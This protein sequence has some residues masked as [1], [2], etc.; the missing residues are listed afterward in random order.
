V[1]KLL[2]GFIM[3]LV[4]LIIAYPLDG[5]KLQCINDYLLIGFIYIVGNTGAC[6]FGAGLA[7]CVFK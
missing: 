4:I 1:R 6:L 7:E 2:V 3:M 5:M